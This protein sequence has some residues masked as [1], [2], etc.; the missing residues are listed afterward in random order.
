[1]RLTT[2][3]P[4]VS[5]LS[6]QCGILNVLQSCRPPWP[7]KGIAL[8][9]LMLLGIVHIRFLPDSSSYVIT[10][11]DVSIRALNGIPNV[12]V[13]RVLGKRLHSKAYKRLYAFKCKRFRNNRH[14]V[15]F[16]MQS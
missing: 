6:R 5:Q 2:T 14:T 3:P 1:V 8:L 13:W 10:M 7:L 11:Q 15:T 12:A 4:S 16:G 9:L